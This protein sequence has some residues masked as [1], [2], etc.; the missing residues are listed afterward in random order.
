MPTM[1]VLG[2]SIAFLRRHSVLTFVLMGA[3]F[4]LSGITSVNLYVVLTANIGLFRMYGSQAIDDGALW[5]LAEILATGFLSV[6]FFV[7][8]IVCERVFVDRLTA[9]L[10]D[11]AGESN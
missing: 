11:V 3:F 7:L 6:L 10:R 4:L 2:P 8:F 5:Q 1:R 9:N